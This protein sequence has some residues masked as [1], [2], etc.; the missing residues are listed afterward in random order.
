MTLTLLP[1]SARSSCS[2]TPSPFCIAAIAITRPASIATASS[3]HVRAAGSP[4]F[5][6][7]TTASTIN[8]P[9]YAVA[10]GRLPATTVSTANTT[11]SRGLVS[12]T[13]AIARRV[14]A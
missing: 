10:A 14:Y 9:T 1:R 11:I 6:A 3:A 5:D 8:F 12:Q 7:V 4:V 2:A 13:S